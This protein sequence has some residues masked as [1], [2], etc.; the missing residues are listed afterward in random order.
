M[1]IVKVVELPPLYARVNELAR[2][3]G[4]K[5]TKT[6]EYVNK[7]RKHPTFS[8]YIRNP[9][10]KVLLVNIKGFDAYL[11]YIDLKHLKE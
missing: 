7:M 10:Y 8:S 5:A 6:R 11:E 9:S 3:F 4:L 2:L 1:D